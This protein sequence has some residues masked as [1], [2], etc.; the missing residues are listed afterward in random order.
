MKRMSVAVLAVLVLPLAGCGSD[1]PDES[2]TDEPTAEETTEETAGQTAETGASVEAAADPGEL[3]EEDVAAI[4]STIVTVD[5]EG[6]C[7][8]VTDTF[9]EEQTFISEPE[10]AC[11]AYEK[12]FVDKQYTEQDLVISEVTGTQEKATAT[13]GSTIADLT[14]QYTL[15]N[16]DGTWMIDAVD[17]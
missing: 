17:F 7:D 5:M 8:L 12:A 16:Q 15:V 1:D 6:G 11:E 4:A 10:Q 9:L 13:F 14:I 2:A 3:T